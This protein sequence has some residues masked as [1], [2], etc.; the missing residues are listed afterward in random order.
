MQDRPV[1]KED[2]FHIVHNIYSEEANKVL[3]DLDLAHYEDQS[4]KERLRY[5]PIEA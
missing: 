3:I 1:S 2:Y 4:A 5:L